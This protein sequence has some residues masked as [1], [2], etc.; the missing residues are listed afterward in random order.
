MV[1]TAGP[2][3]T[4]PMANARVEAVKRRDMALCG[5]GMVWE[6]IKP[7]WSAPATNKGKTLGKAHLAPITVKYARDKEMAMP[8][9]L[10]FCVCDGWCG[11]DGWFVD[12]TSSGRCETLSSLSETVT[13]EEAEETCNRVDEG[14]NDDCIDDDVE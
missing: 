14:V 3:T 1:S 10:G 11:G 12:D 9:W 7:P 13:E 5:S 8:R 2:N 6:K 4:F